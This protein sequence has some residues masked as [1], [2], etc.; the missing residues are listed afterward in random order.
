MTDYESH[1]PGEVAR[2]GR[3][4][5]TSSSSRPTPPSGSARTGL[6]AH[7]PALVLREADATSAG[8]GTGAVVPAAAPVHQLLLVDAIR[9]VWW[10]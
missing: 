8:V 5:V 2:Q 4:A 1:K 10:R 3:A 7:L 9:G 6:D